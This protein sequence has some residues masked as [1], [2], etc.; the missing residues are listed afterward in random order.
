MPAFCLITFSASMSVST[1]RPRSPI[2]ARAPC[3]TRSS[4]CRRCASRSRCSPSSASPRSSAPCSSSTSRPTTTSTSS[5]RSGPRCSARRGSIRV[6]SAWWFLLIL[7]F[8]VVST[9]LCI[10][11]NAPQ[12][13]CA[14]CAPTRKH[15]ASRRCR[16]STTR[17]RPSVAETPRRGAR[18]H[19]PAAGR[20]RLEGQGAACATARRDGG[21][22]Q[23]RAP[24]SSATSRRTR[25][26]C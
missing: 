18:A 4:C 12:D 11:R 6:Y 19:R 9:S 14:T 21:G 25:R 5:A 20:R 16:P 17:P 22:A 15:C 13:R 8:L 7:A 2:A 24:T 3:A 1:H 10:A 23:G 26:S